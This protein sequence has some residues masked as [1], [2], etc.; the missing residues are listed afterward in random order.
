MSAC[1]QY[2]RF[3]GS[4]QSNMAPKS[5]MMYLTT[6][7]TL[8]VLASMPSQAG[9][10]GAIQEDYT[11][12]QMNSTNITKFE[13]IDSNNLLR[14]VG[15]VGCKS[16]EDR[17]AVNQAFADAIEIAAAVA[18]TVGDVDKIDPKL[19]HNKVW[20]GEYDPKP[21]MAITGEI[22]LWYPWIAI[23]FTNKQAQRA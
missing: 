17:K 23:V 3:D 2:T 4:T 11:L 21:W 13:E 12:K 5:F 8:I 10:I 18:P 22:E 1:L 6:F 19:W 16:K 20:W 14:I 9:T 7:I 15:L